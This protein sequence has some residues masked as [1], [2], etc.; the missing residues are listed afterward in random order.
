LTRAS[1]RPRRG[2]HSQKSST[3]FIRMVVPNR[4]WQ[5]C[6]ALVSVL[7]LVCA[8]SRELGAQAPPQG[9][10]AGPIYL[11][12]PEVVA[13]PTIVDKQ[14]VKDQYADGKPR[15]E[16]QVARFSDNHFEADGPYREFYPDGK[17]F[18]EGQ[19]VRGRREGQWS[20]W[21]D[22]GQINRKATYKQG[23]PDGSWEVFRADGT[24]SAKRS[25]KNGARHGEWLTYDD[26]GKQKLAE[27]HYV[28]AKPDGVWRVWFPSGKL[29]QEGSFKLGVRQGPAIE[30]NENGEKVLELNYAEGKLEG[31]ASRLLPNGRRIVQQ[32]KAGKL[33]SESRE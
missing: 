33:I 16:R 23:Q 21:Y 25:F 31:T 10:S 6:L 12:E 11:P 32:Y 14:L 13:E 24:L 17:V 29:K 2:I 19:F 3:E 8:V 28:D 15:V 7:A 20:F 22:N 4:K 30:W 26:T 18:V 27:E 1:N 9:S 5:R